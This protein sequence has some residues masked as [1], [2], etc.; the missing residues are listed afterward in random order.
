MRIRKRA[1]LFMAQDK[2]SLNKIFIVSDSSENALVG[3][4]KWSIG[5]MLLIGAGL[6]IVGVVFLLG[7]VGV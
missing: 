3:G 2:K 4:M 5:G 6:I 1:P 7:L